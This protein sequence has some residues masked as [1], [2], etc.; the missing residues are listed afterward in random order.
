MAKQLSGKSRSIAP[1][2]SL[3]DVSLGAFIAYK[4]AQHDLKTGLVIGDIEI[5]K[6]LQERVNK[7]T[8]KEPAIWSKLNDEVNEQVKTMAA[9]G[10]PSRGGPDDMS[11]ASSALNK[12]SG[13]SRQWPGYG[14]PPGY[15]GY[16]SGG[17]YG[18]QS[19]TNFQYQNGMRV[20]DPGAAVLGGLFQGIAG[21][22]NAKNPQKNAVAAGIL[23]GLGQ[24]FTQASQPTYF[25]SG[26]IQQTNQGWNNNW[27]Q[28]FGN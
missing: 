18:N 16:R 19:R 20:Q 1:S 4:Q 23:Q 10:A 13:A 5:L 28:G 25:G 27:G 12:L 9:L 2:L 26:S 15:G 22:L 7:W 14:Y 11:G 8:E 6:E 17:S 24:G 21:G 3:D